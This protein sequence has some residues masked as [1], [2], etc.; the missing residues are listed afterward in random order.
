MNYASYYKPRPGGR[1]TTP[2]G[3]GAG[4]RVGWVIGVI[5]GVLILGNSCSG[6]NTWRMGVD[7]SGQSVTCQDGT[8]SL[9]GDKQGACSQHGGVR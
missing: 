6:S 2:V 3:G 9:S 5:V 4:G 8:T 7:G 1:G